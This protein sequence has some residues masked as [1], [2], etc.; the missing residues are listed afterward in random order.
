[1][2]ITRRWQPEPYQRLLQI[3]AKCL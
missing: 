3:G 2:S 1:V